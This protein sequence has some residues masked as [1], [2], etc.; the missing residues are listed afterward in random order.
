MFQI[1]GRNSPIE[2]KRLWNRT[3]TLTFCL[4]AQRLKFA[5]MLSAKIHFGN[6]S[7]GRQVLG[8]ELSV[9]ID[10]SWCHL[11]QVVRDFVDAGQCLLSRDVI[12]ECAIFVYEVYT[13][14]FNGVVDD[15][16]V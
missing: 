4:A 16:V 11:Y 8:I 1:T 9:F 6:D 7:A 3:S 15:V 13:L 12:M 14:G 10:F 5:F 2:F